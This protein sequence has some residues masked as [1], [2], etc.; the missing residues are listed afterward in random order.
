MKIHFTHIYVIA[1]LCK[2]FKLKGIHDLHEAHSF[3]NITE[4][5]HK[6]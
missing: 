5:D 4:A 1:S 2:A 6:E 3:G